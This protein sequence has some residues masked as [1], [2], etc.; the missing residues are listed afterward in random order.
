[1]IIQKA[2]VE[3]CAEIYQLISLKAEFDRSTGGF[4]GEISTSA[5]TIKSTLFGTLP[6]AHALIA[7]EQHLTLGLALYHFKYS[8]FSGKP[9]IW[10]DDLFVIESSRS[11]DIGAGLMSHLQL[12]AKDHDCSHISWTASPN[13]ERGMKFYNNLGASIERMEGKRPFYRLGVVYA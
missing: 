8:S 4:I 3:N 6:Y 9:S 13:N 12:D 7:K 1:M 10:L 11:K 5:E 2:Q